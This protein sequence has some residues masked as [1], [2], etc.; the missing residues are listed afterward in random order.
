[1]IEIEPWEIYSV[2]TGTIRLDGG[3]MFG[4]VPKVLWESVADV[5]NLN[6]ILLATRT[7]MAVDRKGQRVF[8]VDTGCG[9]KW[10][11]EQAERYAIQY[12]AEAIPEALE[13]IGL[14]VDN[15]TDVVISHL[16]FDHNGG[17]THWYDEP[18]GPACLRFPKA[19]HWVHK[20]HWEHANRPHVKDR[21][22]FIREDFAALA[23]ADVLRLVEGDR[24]DSPHAGLEWYVSSGHTP[25]QLHPVFGTRRQRLMFVG[26]L[27]PTIAHLPLGWVMA[28]DMLP[29]T[30]ISEKET[31]VRRC[32]D[33][34]MLIA[35][36]HDPT[37]GGVELEGPVSR[38]IVIRELP[39]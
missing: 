18:G 17:L 11:K 21:A 35:F 26:D 32:V 8:L 6:R 7:L 34:G 14:S 16:H 10:A 5:D 3:A 37:A 22:S 19:A 28:Y 23:D 30:A 25:C 39:L 12:D 33:E 29:M 36:P 4:V 31:I 13:S 15:V 9:T 27:I 2:V 20:T 38:P 24:P 1:M